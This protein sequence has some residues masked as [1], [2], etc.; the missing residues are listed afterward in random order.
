MRVEPRLD[1]R[2]KTVLVVLFFVTLFAVGPARAQAQPQATPAPT[3]QGQQPPPAYPP[4]GYPPPA[5]PPPAY[6][7]AGYPPAGY[8]QAG[9]PPPAPYPYPTPYAQYPAQPS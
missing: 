7:P 8:P 4:P 1:L 5:Y 2:K 3:A 9:Y 6:P